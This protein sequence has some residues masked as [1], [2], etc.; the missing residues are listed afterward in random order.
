MS[1]LT[2]KGFAGVSVGVID[3]GQ[4]KTWGLILPPSLLKYGLNDD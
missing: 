3:G 4:C 1:G 2:I